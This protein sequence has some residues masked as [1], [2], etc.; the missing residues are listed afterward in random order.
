M[1][2][3]VLR[4]PEL[5]D[6]LVRDMY[7]GRM[8]SRWISETW[9]GDSCV[10]TGTPF[11]GT[12][13]AQALFAAAAHGIAF[14]YPSA[15]PTFDAD[16][17]ES[18]EIT[19]SPTLTQL[20]TENAS[21][22]KTAFSMLSPAQRLKCFAELF[23][24]YPL[25]SLNMSL[26]ATAI[27]DYNIV[28][29]IACLLVRAIDV[30]T[31]GLILSTGRECGLV[32]SNEP[33]VTMT[34][35]AQQ[36]YIINVEQMM[37]ANVYDQRQVTLVPHARIAR[38]RRGGDVKFAPIVNGTADMLQGLVSIPMLPEEVDEIETRGF[39]DVTGSMPRVPGSSEPPRMYGAYRYICNRLG[40]AVSSATDA[41]TIESYV[42]SA[43]AHE[44]DD[45]VLSRPVTACLRGG[46]R[47]QIPG[48][49]T[50][51]ICKDAYFGT[52][53]ADDSDGLVLRLTGVHGGSLVV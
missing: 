13:V 51:T 40:L 31:E 42:A 41:D 30:E 10:T 44:A 7:S 46:T 25:E 52:A 3:A 49:G 9:G 2:K 5:K 22:A 14:A 33:L 39:F 16:L 21:K 48:H 8:T 18:R 1:L 26:V 50:V 53:D 37:G 29:P 27:L 4:V 12:A 23:F 19:L 35:S 28:F 45:P 11:T 15:L 6:K 47:M 38:F 24:R 43:G 36:T 20:S 32:T 17:L 34:N